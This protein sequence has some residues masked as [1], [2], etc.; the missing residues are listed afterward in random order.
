LSKN[1]NR[2]T[3]H[4]HIIASAEIF[5]AISFI[6]IGFGI[7]ILFPPFFSRGLL[8]NQDTSQR[9]TLKGKGKY[10]LKT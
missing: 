3:L 4:V 2:P 10:K 8:Y 1:S 7:I 9:K 5:V 6:V